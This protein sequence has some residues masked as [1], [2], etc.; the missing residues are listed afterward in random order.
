MQG[1]RREDSAGVLDSTSSPTESNAADMP[2]SAA[3][4]G[5]SLIIRVKDNR[6]PPYAMNNEEARERFANHSWRRMFEIH[7]SRNIVAR[8]NASGCPV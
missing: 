2:G 6:I 3:A 4:V 7:L 8:E 1:A 5:A